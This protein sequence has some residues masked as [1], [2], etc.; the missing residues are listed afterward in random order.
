MYAVNGEAIVQGS[1]LIVEFPL[2][3]IIVAVA[4]VVGAAASTIGA[5]W[6]TTRDLRFAVGRLEV[7]VTKLTR[8]LDVLEKSTVDNRAEIMVLK[9]RMADLHAPGGGGR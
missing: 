7:A 8:E 6:I 5:V 3:Q 4:T 9:Q 1:A 2:W